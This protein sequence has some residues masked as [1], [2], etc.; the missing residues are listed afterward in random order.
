MTLITAQQPLGSIYLAASALLEPEI[1][2][3]KWPYWP[4]PSEPKGVRE[5][6][7]FIE[8]FHPESRSGFADLGQSWS[9]ND[10]AMT[11][12]P[13]WVVSKR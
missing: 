6:S 13:R 9:R 4:G 7:E 5:L 2:E 10:S 3:W 1:V 11:K 8:F 12:L